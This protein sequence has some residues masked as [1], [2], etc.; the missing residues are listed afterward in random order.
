MRVNKR[1][2]IV[3]QK[4]RALR[5]AKATAI[6]NTGSYITLGELLEISKTPVRDC[7]RKTEG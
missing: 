1:M 2:A 5:A 7:L 6:K 4:F 3:K